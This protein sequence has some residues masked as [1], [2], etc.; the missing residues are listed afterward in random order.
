MKALHSTNN[1]VDLLLAEFHQSFVV[2]PDVE[3]VFEG[4]GVRMNG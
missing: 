3:K 4:Q 2:Y 1:D